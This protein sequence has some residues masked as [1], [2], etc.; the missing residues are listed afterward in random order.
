MTTLWG[1]HQSVVA[2]D[3]AT[4]AVTRLTPPSGCAAVLADDGAHLFLRASSLTSLPT[5]LYA[6][7][8]TLAVAAAPVE[9]LRAGPVVDGVPADAVAAV[10]ATACAHQRT[11]VGDGATG[12]IASRPRRARVPCVR[13]SLDLLP[14]RLRYNGDAVAECERCSMLA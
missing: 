2:V 10:A 13:L 1:A 8:A 4:G 3:V 5:V 6:P 11:P 7:L 9:W 12:A 14:S